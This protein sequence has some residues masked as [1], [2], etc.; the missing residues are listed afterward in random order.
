MKTLKYSILSL[1]SLFVMSCTD[2]I[3]LDIPEGERLIII[4]GR[5]TDSIPVFAQILESAPIFSEE[6][7]PTIDNAL[8]L[9]FEDD[10]NVATLIQDTSGIYI[11]DFI[12]TVGKSYRL[13]VTVPADHP[14]LGN[15]T[16]A[17]AE[18]LMKP[19]A[20]LDSMYQ[21]TVEDLPPFQEAGEY[22]FYDFTETPGLGDRIRIRAWKNDTLQG[23]GGSITVFDDEFIDGRTFTN[24]SDVPNAL[25]AI[26]VHF[27]PGEDQEKWKIEHS[28]ISADYM[29]YLEL[30]SQ[31]TAQTGGLFDP[32]PALLIGNIVGITNPSK[33]GLGFFAASS[34]STLEATI[35]L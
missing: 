6:L 3:D 14:E 28:S 13:E 23:G 7:N 5:V 10:I 30:V 33:T 9:L 4:N 12:G 26:Q 31:Q 2:I 25:P 19:V 32:P 11:A 35:K 15:T 27:S 20:P 18:E 16:W 34:I 8:V 24:N 17:S 1:A 22:L 29:S 21:E